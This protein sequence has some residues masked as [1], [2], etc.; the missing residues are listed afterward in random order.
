M[1]DMGMGHGTSMGPHGR[2]RQPRS[3]PPISTTLALVLRDNGRRVLTYADLRSLDGS[4]RLPCA[5]TGNRAASD[6]SHGALR[7]VFQRP[8]VLREPSRLQFN[9]GERLRLVLINDSM[10]N[11]PIHLH[12]MWGEVEGP[13]G[14]VLFRK[15]TINVQPGQ[16][17]QL[18]RDRG[19]HRPLGLSLPS[20]LSH[21]S[22]HVPRGARGCLAPRTRLLACAAQVRRRRSLPTTSPGSPATGH[23]RYDLQGHGRR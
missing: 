4:D 16:T 12:G 14:Q 8:E 13:D 23:G 15:H 17:T 22:R 1:A 18:S 19:R 10:M 11:H 9:Y 6:R 3:A 20:A 7:L 2:F 5:G 21:G